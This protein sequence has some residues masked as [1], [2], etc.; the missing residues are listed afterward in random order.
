MKLKYFNDELVDKYNIYGY[1]NGGKLLYE[2]EYKDNIVKKSIVYDPNGEVVTL[3]Y[4][5]KNKR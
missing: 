1:M 5:E 2:C 4:N 3:I